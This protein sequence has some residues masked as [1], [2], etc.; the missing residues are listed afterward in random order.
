[1]QSK[2]DN[3]NIMKLYNEKNYNQLARQ[4]LKKPIDEQGNTIIHYMAMNMDREAFDAIRKIQPDKLS[5][6]VINYPNKNGELPI[7]KAVEIA[8]MEN[9]NGSYKHEF[10]TY[11]IEI[12]KANPDVADS[13]NRIVIRE[14]ITTDDKKELERLNETVIKNI[15]NISRNMTETTRSTISIVTNS[16]PKTDF[17]RNITEYY[18][19]QSGGYNGK[20]KIKNYLTENGDYDSFHTSNRSHYT[21][22]SRITEATDDWLDS[23][24]ERSDNNNSDWSDGKSWKAED[25]NLF[26]SDRIT[27]ANRNNFSRSASSRYDDD[28]ESDDTTDYDINLF[29]SDRVSQKS[30]SK[31][32]SPYDN[33]IKL[34]TSDRVSQKSSSNRNSARD[35]ELEDELKSTYRDY[36]TTLNRPRDEKTDELYRSFIKKIQDLLDVDEDTA[37]LYR[38]IIKINIVKLNPELR[39]RENDTL[40]VKEM[41]KILENKNKLKSY[42]DKIDIEATRR[43]MKERQ[44]EGEK[45]RAERNAKRGNKNNREAP[46]TETDVQTSE[47]ESTGRKTRRKKN[48]DLTTDTTNIEKKS[49]KQSRVVDNGYLQS[50][51][52]LISPA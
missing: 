10:I 50:D 12:L 16:D 19:N 5:Y 17:I 26:T 47:T 38:S 48:D 22:S 1:M 30:S 23:M 13:K 29:T 15:N 20:R 45:R 31:R 9:K 3:D 44:E 24:F 49:K 39:G 43:E 42:L 35:Y 7:H 25:F 46:K 21:T 36:M 2:V 34:F 32:N 52:F 18:S 33:D 27:S 11:M 4:N 41:E 51:E 14:D 8:Y 6:D 28:T 37:R 40:K